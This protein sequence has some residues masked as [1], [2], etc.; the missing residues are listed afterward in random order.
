MAVEV[1]R[2]NRSS[3]SAAAMLEALTVAMRAAGET[4]TETT[5]YRGDAEWL[6]LFG[7]GAAAHTEARDRHVK[8]GG[9]VMLWDLGYFGRRKAPGFIRGSINDD[10]PQAWLDRAPTDP[11]RWN[12]QGIRLREDF[13]AAGHVVLVGMGRKHRSYSGSGWER[14]AFADLLKRFP[15]ARIVYRPKNDADQVILPCARNST[16]PIEHLLNGAS[17]VVCRHSNVAIDAA[18]A[19]VPF[20]CS[21]G[22]AMWLKA[23]EFT[24]ENRLDFLRRLA[25]FQWRPDEA[26]EGW[27][28]FKGIACA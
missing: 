11:S 17:L 6:M 12:A 10:H 28:F 23:K 20:E 22:A 15:A 16:S 9:K 27:S 26:S 3:P 24:R 19:G 2:S 25:W 4:F 8:S 21:D 5:E 1:L 18:I 13:R 14:Q 7:V